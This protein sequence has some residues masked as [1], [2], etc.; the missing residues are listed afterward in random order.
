MQLIPLAMVP[1]EGVALY[2]CEGRLAN[3]FLVSGIKV[4]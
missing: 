2:C 1:M 3:S 4:T